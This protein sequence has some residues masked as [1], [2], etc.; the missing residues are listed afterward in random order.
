MYIESRYPDN[1]PVSAQALWASIQHC[2][3]PEFLMAVKKESDEYPHWS[4]NERFFFLA[5]ITVA[6]LNFHLE[7][8]EGSHLGFLTLGN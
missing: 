2:K 7:R 6:N 5:K 1:R 4:E 3:D 8:M